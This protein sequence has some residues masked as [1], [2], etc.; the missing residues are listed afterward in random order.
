MWKPFQPNEGA[1]TE[2]HREPLKDFSRDTI[3]EHFRKVTLTCTES[4]GLGQEWRQG[5]LV[6]G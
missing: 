1:W 5:E 4:T 3:R 2:G 6:R